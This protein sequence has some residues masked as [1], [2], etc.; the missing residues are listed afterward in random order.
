MVRL[1]RR[2]LLCDTLD[3]FLVFFEEDGAPAVV[4][5]AP[6]EAVMAEA[7]DKEVAGRLPLQNFICDGDLSQGLLG[8]D[9]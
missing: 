7:E 5:C 4:Q 8:S 6:H 9:V 3:P 2:E 1:Q